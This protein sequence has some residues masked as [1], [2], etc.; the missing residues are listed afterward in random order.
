[1]IKKLAIFVTSLIGLEIGAGGCCSTP[2]AAPQQHVQRIIIQQ[3]VVNINNKPAR[4][5]KAQRVG[6]DRKEDK[7]RTALNKP[8]KGKKANKTQ[9]S[10][11]S[12]EEARA[13]LERLSKKYAARIYLIKKEQ[14]Y[15]NR[16][17]NKDDGMLKQ[18]IFQGKDLDSLREQVIKLMAE[19]SVLD[20]Q[21]NVKKMRQHQRAAEEN[22]KARTEKP[23][24]KRNK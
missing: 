6:G 7:K 9:A 1:M 19:V 21:N 16:D 18:T 17:W 8:G 15:S 12:V 22:E 11:L 5:A 20:G 2:Q 4:V 13:I 24:K 10:T 3:A 23:A 14:R